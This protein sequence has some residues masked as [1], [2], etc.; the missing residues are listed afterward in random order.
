MDSLKAKVEY[1]KFYGCAELTVNIYLPRTK[2]Q[3]LVFVYPWV[4]R[5]K[6]SKTGERER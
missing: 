1:G 3:V 4:E 5:R 6:G 2:H